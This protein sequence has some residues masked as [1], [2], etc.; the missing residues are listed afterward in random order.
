MLKCPK[1]K[2]LKAVPR[3]KNAIFSDFVELFVELC[4]KTLEPREEEN[5]VQWFYAGGDFGKH[6]I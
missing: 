6:W 3:H 1:I 4:G 2:T 5:V